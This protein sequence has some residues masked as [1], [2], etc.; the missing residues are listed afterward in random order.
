MQVPKDDKMQK[1]KWL[2]RQKKFVGI[3]DRVRAVIQA[4]EGMTAQKIAEKVDHDLSW[5]QKWVY[6]YRDN[7]IEGLFDKPRPGAPKI[8]SS[9]KEVLFKTRIM[10]GPKPED[11]VS[12]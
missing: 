6:R 9:D 4:L 7:C 12:I 8:L 5:V 10:A 1:L 2:A 3:R 11:K